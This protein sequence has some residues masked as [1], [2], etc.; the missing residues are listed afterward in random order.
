MT[1]TRKALIVD[2][3]RAVQKVSSRMLKELGFETKCAGDGEEA[4]E[5]LKEEGRLPEVVLIDWNMP[6][7]DGINLV[8]ELRDDSRFFGMALL[9]V[10]SEANETHRQIAL[11]CGVDDYLSKPYDRL[12]LLEKLVELGICNET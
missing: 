3:S 6:K 9:M 5:V 11:D 2:D 10:T 8:K 1:T 7:M 12:T 4:L